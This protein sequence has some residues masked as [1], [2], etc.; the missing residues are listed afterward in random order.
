MANPPDQNHWDS[1]FN[2]ET[3]A[4]AFDQQISVYKSRELML[5]LTEKVADKLDKKSEALASRYTTSNLSPIKIVS[6]I[7]SA[8]R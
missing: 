5:R 6:V 2:P 8:N 7:F 3:S 4:S 1:D